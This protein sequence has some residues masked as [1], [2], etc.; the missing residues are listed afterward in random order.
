[1]THFRR[2]LV[3]VAI[4]GG[5]VCAPVVLL[6][7]TAQAHPLGNQT[8]NHY[9]GLTIATDHIDDFAVED[10]AEIPTLQRQPG[11]DADGSGT[12]SDA[13]RASYAAAQCS[14]LSQ[15]VRL[16]VADR[17]IP[18][19]LVSSAYAQRPGAAGLQIGR[20]EC[21]LTAKADVSAA[22]H[23]A[24]DDTW[25]A[26]ALG[27]HEI[28][29]VGV[30]VS[31]TNS[32]VPA[33]SLSDTLLK[34]PNDNL[35]SPLDVRSATLQ[36][37]PGG[38]G[39]TYVA[40]TPGARPNWA[41]RTVGHLTTKLNDLVKGHLDAGVGILAVL[42]SMLLGAGHAMLPGHGKTIMA[43]YLVGKRGRLR[44]VV[45]VG[46]TVTITHTAGVLILGALVSLS[47][48]FATT[49]VE[50]VLGVIS[51]LIIVLVGVTLFV[52]ALR[53]RSSAGATVNASIATVEAADPTFVVAGHSL[54][55]DAA[56]NRPRSSV[57][58]LITVPHGH[59]HAPHNHDH[60]PHDHAPHDHAPHDH[61]PHDRAVDVTIEAPHSHGWLGGGHS[62]G[63]GSHTHDPLEGFS[64]RGLIGLGAAGGLVPSPSALLVL[65]ATI[66]LGRT[67]FGVLLVLAY[68]VGMAGALTIAG[69]LLVKFRNRIASYGAGRFRR[70]GRIA[71][72]LPLGTAALVIIVGLG[73]AARS[74]GG[75]L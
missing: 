44:D 27:W 37:T 23:V 64:R 40:G 53:R 66:A 10:S 47:A 21:R 69:L 8:V 2:R 67:A 22:T 71:A 46:A 6:V 24:L 31:L 65:V 7:A 42:L 68:G 26:D 32:P 45:T 25:D 15:G 73:L 39:S 3:R 20:L 14:S 74:Y 12:L 11:I 48:T 70:L 4:A 29:A 33:T 52:S 72:L 9:D 51:G 75:S 28:T 19:T 62:H 18:W 57:A 54:R 60:A 43:A 59:D 34:Y 61:A 58:T 5:I 55:V 16:S 13:E 35:S 49:R 36:V 38:G 41:A 17:A 56:A 30:G 63:P 1:M 50:Q